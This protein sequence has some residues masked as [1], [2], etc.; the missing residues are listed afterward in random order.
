MAFS[1]ERAKRAVDF[2]ELLPHT[3]GQWAGQ[4]F[5]LA[6]WQRTEIIE[7]L[8]GTIRDDGTRQYRTAY[9]EI[10]RKNG[11]S[12]LASGVANYLLYADNEPGAQIYGAAYTRDQASIVFNVARQMVEKTPALLQRSKVLDSVK[13][14][15]VPGTDSFYRAI[16]SDDSTSH[17]FN[18]HG[19]IF[20][21][22]HTQRSRD[23]WDVLTTSTGARRQPLT[24]AITTAGFDRN[25]ICWELHTYAIGLLKLR[26]V[27][28]DDWY[29]DIPTAVVDDPSFFACVYATPEEWDW[30]DEVNWFKA[31]PGLG[32]FRSLDEMREKATKAAQMPAAQNAFRRLYLNQWTASESRWLDMGAWDRSAGNVDA[33]ELR[34]H[35]CYG[36]LD[37]SATTD[38]TAFVLA[39]PPQRGGGGYK[40]LPHFWLPAEGI[41]DRE[42]MDRV[43]YRVWA[44]QGYLTLTQGATV[45]YDTVCAYIEAQGALYNIEEIALDPW[46]AYDLKN[47]LVKADKTVVEV[48][49]NFQNMSSPSKELERLVL[50]QKLEHG[51]NPVLRW[52]ADNVVTVEDENG[53]IRPS[54]KRSLQRI[55]GITALILALDR[56]QRQQTGSSVYDKREVRSLT[57]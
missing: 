2:I 23:L 40:F 56:A 36:G 12:M 17:G 21:E 42:K 46:G 37:L 48:R 9:I 45:D 41:E 38:L 29:K 31:N 51:G 39:F 4:R 43:P 25:S 57:L 18:A 34:G 55:D 28:P 5:K 35:A 13:R 20:D 47:R 8:F 44:Q 3:V 1:P 22:L 14:I 54:K 16:P 10:P 26:G 24:F 15:V 19:I 49:Q 50:D 33:I 11:K 53:N 32:V 7:P 6:D 27:I 30:Q 52:N